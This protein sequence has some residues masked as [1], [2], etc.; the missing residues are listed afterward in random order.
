MMNEKELEYIPVIS[1]PDPERRMKLFVQ[2]VQ[3]QLWSVVLGF[4]IATAMYLMI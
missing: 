1:V 4:V 3:K 2:A